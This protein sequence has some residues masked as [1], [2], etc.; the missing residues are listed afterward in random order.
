MYF[1]GFQKINIF[2]GMKILWIVFGG[3]HK[4]G[5]HLGVISMH[6]G[7]FLRPRYRMGVFLGVAKASNIFGGSLKF[8][9]LFWGEQQML[10]PSLR[11]SKK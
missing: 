3:H 4:I 5:L 7:S 10:G 8:F 1:W 9:I 2:G 11:M 6:L